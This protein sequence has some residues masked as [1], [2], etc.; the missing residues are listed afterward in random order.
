M[1]RPVIT[2]VILAAVCLASLPGCSSG[3]V[4]VGKTDSELKKKTDGGATGNGQICSWAGTV[5]DTPIASGTATDVANDD[6]RV[7]PTPPDGNVSS[8]PSTGETTPGYIPPC[9]G[10]GPYR[11][12]DD[13]KSPDGCNE[14]SCT[15]EGITCTIRQC[16]VP[17]SPPSPPHACTAEAK[18]CPDG[19]SVGRSGPNCEFAPCPGATTPIACQDD[20][21]VCPDGTVLG[22]VGPTCEFPACPTPV[23]CTTDAKQCPDGSFVGRVAPK[24]EFAACP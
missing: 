8:P 19:S 4:A 14:C 3:D 16:S 13:F 24:C 18:I 17:P 5:Y 22:R 11:V 10:D 20:A 7:P 1:L 12:G 6:R 9:N 23:A 2:S 21:R 15:P